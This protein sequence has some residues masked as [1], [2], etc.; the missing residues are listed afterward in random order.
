MA[1][2]LG[3]CDDLSIV[4]DTQLTLMHTDYFRTKS[5]HPKFCRLFST[6]S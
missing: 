4:I 5:E 6:A 3:M 1:Q 2:N